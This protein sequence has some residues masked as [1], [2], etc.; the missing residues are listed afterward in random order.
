MRQV[1]RASAA[2]ENDEEVPHPLCF[3]VPISARSLL[4]QWWLA[5][6]RETGFADVVTAADA[7][8]GPSQLQNHQ[9]VSPLR[10][11]V[12]LRKKLSRGAHYNLRLLVRGD[13]QTGKTQLWRRLQ[14]LPFAPNL[15]A[16]TELGVAHVDWSD[17]AS[18]DVVKVEAWDVSD[19]DLSR[20]QKGQPTLAF[21]QHGGGGGVCGGGGSPR[22][23]K[24][25]AGGAAAGAASSSD[26]VSPANIWRDAHAA[27]VLFDPRKPWTWAYVKRLFSEAP[28]EVPVLVLC[29]YADLLLPADHAPGSS[30]PSATSA[31]GD[32]S[33]PSTT[34]AG[35]TN[36]P[37]GTPPPAQSAVINYHHHRP[38][39]QKQAWA[40]KWE[41][42][43]TTVAAERTRTGRTIVC[44][45][46][47]SALDMR[48]LP[49]VHAFLKLPYLALTQAAHERAR[50]EAH[51]RFAQAAAALEEMAAAGGGDDAAACLP[52]S[53]G[54]REPIGALPATP[55]SA[56]FSAPPKLA[57]PPSSTPP[58]ARPNT[59]S[60]SLAGAMSGLAESGVVADAA[61][62]DESFFDGLD[63]PAPA[64]P[65]GASSGASSSLALAHDSLAEPDD[66]E[67]EVMD[68]LPLL[69][70]PDSFYDD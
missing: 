62:I 63:A 69:D 24:G 20:A 47:Y 49:A 61:S 9:S 60:A 4:M 66:A 36:A 53:P 28:V 18:A 6:Q 23:P 15:P 1:V 67:R 17:G 22:S 41:E 35:A 40:V 5:V 45:R 16:S 3:F 38:Q 10:M 2:D 14:G 8:D 42:V 44:V 43:E 59:G 50:E 30:A 7:A 12:Q 34:L 48:G 54:R 31:S 13:L 55:G 33:T 51:G 52:G 21:E 70:D 32:G 26:S 58:S 56:A 29:G 19:G 64:A 65:S 27:V 37:M 46:E 39:P 11:S 68:M 57:P 25:G